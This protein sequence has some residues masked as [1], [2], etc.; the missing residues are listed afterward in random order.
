MYHQ[1][2]SSEMFG[3]R[4]LALLEEAENRRLARRAAAGGAINKA[5]SARVAASGFLATLV[6][7]GI[8]LM[9]LG[10]PA[11]AS[12][13]F[14]VTNTFDPGNGICDASCTLNEAIDAANSTPNS[15]GP[16]L[17]RFNIPGTGVKTISPDSELPAI[18]EAVTID[19]YTQPGSSPNTLAKGTNAKLM[20]EL[21]GTD[22]GS[23]DDGLSVPASNVVIRG[24]VINRWATN[25]ISTEHP[26]GTTGIRIE[27][28]FI[29]TD[30]SG[31]I[32]LGNGRGIRIEDTSNTIV[33]G[34]APEAR[35]LVSGNGPTSGVSIGISSGVK[36]QGNLI[37]TQKDGIS[38]LGNSGDGVEVSSASGN[39]VGGAV[40]G[41]ANTIAFNGGNGVQ[42]GT[43]AG[44]S[45]LSNSIFSNGDQGID[46]NADGPT[47]N[48]TTDA[49]TGSNNLQNTPVIKSVRTSGRA[50]VIKGELNSTP[51]KPFTIQ[52][53]SNP[54]GEAEGKTFIGETSVTT[55]SSGDASFTFKKKV[56]GALITATATNFLTDDT[57][58]FSAP[59]KVRRA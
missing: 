51:N 32:D 23:F 10:S 39:L 25:G 44:D 33:G 47:L 57:S 4:Q 6:V 59:K 37:G 26:S 58:E 24:L 28:N 5:R 2:N 19:G 9:G 55:D 1:I 41:S 11:H 27:G 53:F 48:D 49:D 42:I 8:M 29:G 22:A 54:R 36:V 34:V 12:T 46:L 13:T 45:V 18:T 17:I 3:E 14:T 40:A 56:R 30:P 21:V 7:A 15:D 50:T 16:D 43:G 20:I 38:P 52:L 35:N 31:T